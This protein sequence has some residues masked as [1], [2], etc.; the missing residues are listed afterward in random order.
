MISA[1][2]VINTFK[3]LLRITN[4]TY[5]LSRCSGA[6]PICSNIRLMASI[7]TVKILESLDIRIER[8]LSLL[9]M[10]YSALFEML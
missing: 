1:D 6:S 8:A 4:I 10:P 5:L 9:Y 7:L 3:P 2:L